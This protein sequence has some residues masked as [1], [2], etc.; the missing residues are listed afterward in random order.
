VTFHI[1][2]W[3]FWA[4]GIPAAIVV[5][6]LAIFGAIFLWKFRDWKPFG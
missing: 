5:L 4:F 1:P 3:V 6:G 2:V